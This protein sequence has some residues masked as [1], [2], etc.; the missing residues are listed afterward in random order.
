MT[1]L[2]F[3]LAFWYPFAPIF[4]SMHFTMKTNFQ[5]MMR[6][7]RWSLSDEFSWRAARRHPRVPDGEYACDAFDQHS[8][9]WCGCC[10]I[11]AVVQA[12]EDR[13]HI[14]RPRRARH[15][16]DMQTVVDHFNTLVAARDGWNACHGGYP[17]HVVECL[18]SGVCPLLTTRCR[19]WLGH[20]ARTHRTPLNTA[21]F[22]VTGVRRVPTSKVMHEIHARGPVVLEIA[23]E[24]LKA[25]DVEGVVTD[26]TLRESNHAV[27]VVGWTRRRGERCWI[28]RN[29][30]GTH[31]VPKAIPDDVHCVD[32]DGNRCD[33]VRWEYWSGD[34]E[35]PGFCYIPMSHPMFH[36]ADTTPWIVPSVYLSSPPSH[37]TVGTIETTTDRTSSRAKDTER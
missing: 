14:A 34:P 24:A 6:R 20:P 11:V 10:Y 18:A 36:H 21:P 27:A 7:K 5:L 31:R 28:V 23:A 30:W 19:R 9:G 16:V 12:I 33:N 26:A 35:L 4:L 13:G 22:R 2:A 32:E 29:S 25:L 17:E 3:A 37:D 1:A 8:V 15:K